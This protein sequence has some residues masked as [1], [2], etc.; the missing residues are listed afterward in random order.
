ML[1]EEVEDRGKWQERMELKIED[2]CWM[3]K[4]VMTELRVLKKGTK[5]GR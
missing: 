5:G 1:V 4:M 2:M 3:L